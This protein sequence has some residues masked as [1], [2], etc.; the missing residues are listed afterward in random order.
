MEEE[1]NSS[2]ERGE[3][4]MR[5][6]LTIAFRT[7]PRMLSGLQELWLTDQP[8]KHAEATGLILGQMVL[9][10]RTV[11]EKVLPVVTEFVQANGPHGVDSIFLSALS[12][13]SLYS[14]ANFESGLEV[15]NSLDLSKGPKSKSEFL[16]DFTDLAIES[17]AIVS[18]LL[19][20][21]K[22]RSH[23]AYSLPGMD[24]VAAR[25]NAARY[26]FRTPGFENTFFS[27][28][29]S[30][31]YPDGIRNAMYLNLPKP[32]QSG[33]LPGFGIAL[34]RALSPF[35]EFRLPGASA[36]RNGNAEAE[37]EAQRVLVKQ[38]LYSKLAG[39]PE[40]Q[41]GAHPLLSLFMAIAEG[42]AA[43]GASASSPNYKEPKPWEPAG[44]CEDP[45]AEVKMPLPGEP[46]G[47]GRP[48]LWELFETYQ[49]Y[50]TRLDPLIRPMQED[51][52]GGVTLLKL[53]D[54][55]NIDPLWRDVDFTLPEEELRR[56]LAFLQAKYFD[57]LVN[58]ISE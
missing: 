5:I 58:P 7:L 10:P 45:D 11:A 21:V 54:P 24:A 36:N 23:P 27:E 44:V 26:G 51:V 20:A 48:S 16:I 28:Y 57:S 38:A 56:H 1:E 19:G 12:A 53:P 22:N 4:T 29:I 13:A 31:L 52:G 6:E 37:R 14:I 34:R 8:R 30:K 46:F 40:A 43:T 49:R 17:M 47:T 35:D 42:F 32:S 15:A 25:I 2:E 55:G 3:V 9:H 39:L 18:E 50:I 33:M 41:P